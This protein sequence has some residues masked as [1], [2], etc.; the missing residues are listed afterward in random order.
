MSS[1]I[2]FLALIMF[3]AAG[4]CQGLVVTEPEA[5]GALR[6]AVTFFRSEVSVEGGYLWRY[7]ADLARREGEGV[8]APSMAWVQPPG[9][10]S[11]GSALLAAYTHTGD[12]FYLDAAI[13]SAQALVK[14][15]LRSGGW[16]YRIEF[17]PA[18][19]MEYGYRVTPNRPR[20]NG[21]T[22]LDDNTTQA[23]LRFLMRVDQVLEFKNETI[24]E[25]AQFALE[26]LLRAQYPNG[27][28]PQQ[29]RAPP[30]PAQFPVKRA[31]Y[32]ETWRR[33]YVKRDYR[34]HYTFNDNTIADMIETMLD[35][36]DVYQDARYAASA[37][38]GGDFILLAQMPEPQPGWAQ[39]YDGDMHPAWARKFE[40]P[41]VTGGESRGA[42]QALLTLY[43]STGDRTYLEPVPRALAYFKRSLLSNGKLARFYELETNRPL[44]FTKG[45]DLTYSSDDM[46]THYSFIIANWLDRVGAEYKR[47]AAL[48][49]AQL[50]QPVPD[51][52]SIK[53][54]AAEAARIVA[55]LDARGAWVTDGRLKYH[56][57]DDP[58]MRIIDCAVFAR[59]VRALSAYIAA[60]RGAK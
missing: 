36:A 53:T 15:Q 37:R 43:R 22:T 44:F 23:A 54:T 45:Y 27:A 26:S 19:R 32:P 5:S 14:G 13:E 2:A 16:A 35:A 6:R 51:A 47:V 42:I 20:G 40:P 3:A 41:A 59:N 31:S 12:P 58:A 21:M 24:H 18:K 38:K 46:P 11:V 28:W 33:T 10:P 17:D 1:R 52:A 29:F 48:T 55:A 9:T 50:K 34:G 25:A 49:P 57:D 7:S 60:C 4:W 30:D 56:G 39:Q 8:A